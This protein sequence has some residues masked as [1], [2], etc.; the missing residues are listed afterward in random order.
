[1]TRRRLVHARETIECTRGPRRLLPAAAALLL[2]LAGVGTALADIPEPPPAD[3]DDDDVTGTCLPEKEAGDDC[4]LPNGD[5]GVCQDETEPCGFDGGGT[6]YCHVCEDEG[7][8][9]AGVGM[10]ST[11]GA[12][13]LAIGA[14]AAL[15]LA[16]RRRRR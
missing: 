3:D 14:L 12:S 9:V 5:D 4:K 8:S 15:G 10:S 6:I 1:M 13:W 2:T 11:P 7:C 16:A